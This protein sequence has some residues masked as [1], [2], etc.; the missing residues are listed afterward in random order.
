[1]NAPTLIENAKKGFENVPVGQHYKDSAIVQLTAGL[2]D[3]QFRE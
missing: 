2:A 3:E 1:M